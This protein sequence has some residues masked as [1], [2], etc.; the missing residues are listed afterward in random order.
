MLF[1]EKELN[2]LVEEALKEG[3]GECRNPDEFYYDDSIHHHSKPNIL[4]DDGESSELFQGGE[5]LMW[6]MYPTV[7]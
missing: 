4:W 3:A 7:N 5:D 2:D 1:S 6:E